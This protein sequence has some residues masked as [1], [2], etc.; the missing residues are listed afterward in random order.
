MCH[1]PACFLKFYQGFGA[2]WQWLVQV[3]AT[4]L[5]GSSCMVKITPN[6]PNLDHGKKTFF[7]GSVF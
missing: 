4:V 6:A 7:T 5:G 3:L 1:C 2:Q